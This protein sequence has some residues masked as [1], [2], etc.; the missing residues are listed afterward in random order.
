MGVALYD[1]TSDEPSD[2]E[3]YAGD[4]IVILQQDEDESGWW[5]GELNGQT[6]IFPKTYVELEGGSEF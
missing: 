1:Y 4:R 5:E 6:G 3:F 2:L